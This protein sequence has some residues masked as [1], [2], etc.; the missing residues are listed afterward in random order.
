MIVIQIIQDPYWE[1]VSLGSNPADYTLT[2][3]Q[4][5]IMDHNWVFKPNGDSEVKDNLVWDDKDKQ[6]I[7]YP[8]HLKV[9]TYRQEVLKECVERFSGTDSVLGEQVLSSIVSDIKNA[10]T[11]FDIDAAKKRIED[12]KQQ[13]LNRIGLSSTVIVGSTTRLK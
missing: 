3:G 12:N 5:I 2:D 9:S 10:I 7:L 13:Y 11:V 4:K 6:V 8:E 1:I